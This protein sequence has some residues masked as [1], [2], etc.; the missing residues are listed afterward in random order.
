MADAVVRGESA[1]A[2]LSRSPTAPGTSS[3]PSQPATQ[4]KAL[5]A[6]V[7]KQEPTPPPGNGTDEEQHEP[8][9]AEIEEMIRKAKS[10]GA[11]KGDAVVEETPEAPPATPPETPA[12]P[13]GNAGATTAV[14]ANPDRSGAFA[15]TPAGPDSELPAFQSLKSGPLSKWDDEMAW[16]EYFQGAGPAAGGASIDRDALIR[17]ALTG[18]AADGFVAGLKNVAIDTAINI[19]SS[20]IPYLQ[21]FVEMAKIAYDPAAWLE[22]TVAGTYG[23]A[24]KGGQ[25]LLEG[26]SSGDPIQAL[27]GLLTILEGVNNVIGTLS[28]IC[29]IV[30]AASF[31]LSFICPAALPF[32]SL[33]AS[34]A[35]TLGTISTAFGIYITLGRAL[36]IALRAL[37]IKY[38]NADPAELLQQGERLR[39]Q[40]QAFTSEAT[41]RAGNRMRGAAQQRLQNRGQARTQSP[42]QPRQNTSS[43][44]PPTRMQRIMNA[45]NTGA[46]IVSGGGNARQATRD[47]RTAVATSRAGTRAYRGTGEYAQAPGGGPRSQQ[48]R[49]ADMEHA[50]LTV[51]HNDAARERWNQRVGGQPATN[52]EVAQVRADADARLAAARDADE[53]AREKLRLAE[54][55]AAEARRNRQNLEGDEAVQQRIRDTQAAHAADQERVRGAQRAIETQE[56]VINV[57]KQ[58]RQTRAAAGEDPRNLFIYD[59]HISRAE[60]ELL[61][62][63]TTLANARV[64]EATS[65]VERLR[66]QM[67]LQGAQNLD[68]ERQRELAGAQSRA[69]ETDAERIAAREGVR[70]A[71]HPGQESWRTGG[72]T[73]EQSEAARQRANTQRN[74]WYFDF[75]GQ[76]PTDLHGHN[77]G[78]GVTGAGG[79]LVQNVAKGVA[80]GTTDEQGRDR[81][82]FLGAWE[83]TLGDE[84]M[85]FE[86]NAG[87]RG[88][89]KDYR[90]ILQQQFDDL[91]A[92]LPA[93]PAGVPDQ[94]DGARAAFADLDL[95][96]RQIAFQQEVAASL[97]TE[98][99]QSMT[100][101]TAMQQISAANQEAVA[102]HQGQLD[103]KVT[104]QDDLKA[105]SEDTKGK[106][107]EGEQSGSSTA[108][109][110]GGF[111]SR[112]LDML[113]IVPGRLIGGAGDGAGGIRK[114]ASGAD[115]QKARSADAAT[116]A[117]KGTTEAERMTTETTASHTAAGE[118]KAAL[119]GLD[120][121]LTEEQ[122]STM[123]GQAFLQETLTNAAERQAVLEGEMERLRAEHG[124]AVEAGAGWANDHATQRTEGHAELNRLVDLIERE[125]AGGG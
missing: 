15:A 14:K 118:D 112:F 57:L 6:P 41:T 48:Q 80:G 30:A 35:T 69:G 27:D 85:N 7:Q 55:A 23:N 97:L 43:Q 125:D 100:A 79:D 73:A 29:W 95:E 50:G 122:L 72:M 76:G 39:A 78:A 40:T 56:H 58:E 109:T 92:N 116:M 88:A 101:L 96:A 81:P 67:P 94:I 108:R 65:N 64:A 121:Q 21:G 22:G 10:D 84:P 87:E 104:A 26:I 49:A 4:A 113:N 107:K 115:D 119:E 46:T 110:V 102:A 12:A 2:L 124:A 105:S 31:V 54:E 24:V 8:T 63:R 61:N 103:D 13:E 1:E 25:M 9:E 11:T 37:Q 68:T 51:F 71:Q 53:Q 111:M 47:A 52:R 66:A 60:I 59:Q 114:V 32:A 36:V 98:S 82:G 70:D 89:G 28:T 5:D 75:T 20:R 42:Q 16:H 117:G 34:W 62:R 18:G 86:G 33:A 17:D 38:G 93:P 91:K 19:A 106:A 74:R 44:N 45:L 83:R 123:D 77:K 120:A 90:G 99:E 3:T